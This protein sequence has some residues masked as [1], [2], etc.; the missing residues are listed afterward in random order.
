MASTDNIVAGGEGQVTWDGV[1]TCVD[2]IN[3]DVE[4][5]E[6]NVT[7]TCDYSTTTGFTYPRSKITTNRL[8]GSFKFPWD[9]TKDPFPTMNPGTE[10]PMI[11][12]VYSGRIFTMPESLITGLS[13]AQGGT[14]GVWTVTINWKS[15]G[16]YDM[17]P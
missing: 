17:G 10:S 13:M 5:S 11:L 16:P 1:V 8:V 3:V 14:E 9:R 12:Q 15:Q 7:T 4:A 6:Q 2:D